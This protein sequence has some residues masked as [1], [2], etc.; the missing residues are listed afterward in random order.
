MTED[1][2]VLYRYR[3]LQG[4]HREWTKQILTDSKLY[5]A[6]PLSFNDPFDCKI[7]F[8][9]SLSLNQLKQ[10]Y[11]NLIKKK[12]PGLN[13]KQRKAKVASDLAKI[14]P[15][16]FIAQVTSGL[17]DNVN[18]LG[19]L[20]LSASNKNILLWS[21]YAASHTGLCI[22]FLAS[23]ITPFFGLAQKVKYSSNYPDIDLM[24]NSHDKMVQAFLLTKAIDWQYEDEWR[25]I[26]H[27]AGTGY[28]NFPEELMIEV[29]LG[30]RMETGDREAVVSWLSKR[31]TAVRILQSSL[32]TESFSLRIEPYEP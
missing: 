11:T 23:N 30:A 32:E 26:D 13:R 3:H 31:K 5:F 18:N 16:E 7:H 22:G 12:I 27:D 20:S 14:K 10:K 8:R 19:V 1:P 25:I 29:I 15:D 9:S 17:Q 4:R 28:K 2:Q 21:H 24:N 6:I